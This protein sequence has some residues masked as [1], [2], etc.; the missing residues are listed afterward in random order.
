M[1]SHSKDDKLIHICMRTLV[2]T[3]NKE[4]SE[5]L[6]PSIRSTSPVTPTFKTLKWKSDLDFSF[7]F[8][9]SAA[10]NQHHMNKIVPEVCLDL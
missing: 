10:Q 9:S 4:E 8:S 6:L 5:A 3:W 1:E 2:P 7:F